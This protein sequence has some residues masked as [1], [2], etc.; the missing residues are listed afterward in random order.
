MW[1]PATVGVVAVASV[2]AG[3]VCE[4]RWFEGLG[5]PGPNDGV[6]AMS[7]FDFDGSGQL[8]PELVVGG[9]FTMAGEALCGSAARWDGTRWLAL[10]TSTSPLVFGFASFDADGAGSGSTQLYAGATFNLR[11]SMYVWDGETWQDVAPTI[12]LSARV[13]ESFDPDGEGPLPGRLIV[14]GAGNGAAFGAISQW[15]GVQWLP[16]GGGLFGW[17]ST[18]YPQV[19]AMTSFDPDGAGPEPRRLIV[20]GRFQRAGNLTVNSIAAWDGAAWHALGGGFANGAG[21]GSSARG[22]ALVVHDL[23]GSGPQAPSLVAGGWFERAGGAVVRSLA[24]WDGGS[25]SDVSGG[26]SIE[27]PARAGQ[28]LGLA[29]HDSDGSGPHPA[30]LAVSGRFD[31][32]GSVPS[33]NVA[34]LGEGVWTP[35]S[36][37]GVVVYAYNVEHFPLASF[38]PKGSETPVLVGAASFGFE[39][40]SLNL[41]MAAWNGVWTPLSKGIAGRITEFA[42]L[43]T[44]GSGPQPNEVIVA[45]PFSLVDDGIATGLARFDGQRWRSLGQ[46]GPA[47][48][49]AVTT[50]DP[51]GAGPSAGEVWVSGTVPVPG[52]PIHGIAAWNGSSW[53]QIGSTLDFARCFGTFDF[54]G[55]GPEGARTLSCA[56]YYPMTIRAWD[57]SGWIQVGGQFVLSDTNRFE[58]PEMRAMLSHDFDG[59]GPLAPVLVAAGRFDYVYED[60]NPTQIHSVAQWDGLAWRPIGAGLPDFQVKGAVS[61]DADGAGPGVPWLVV[62][63]P[64]ALVWRGTS[65]EN[66]ALPTEGRDIQIFDPDG[67]GGLPES[68]FVVAADGVYRWSGSSWDSLGEMSLHYYGNTT[69]RAEA[70]HVWR[71]SPA[72]AGQLMVGGL[73]EF[74]GGGAPSATFGRFTCGSCYANC[75]GS[76]GAAV[77]TANDFV[78]FLARFVSGDAYANCDGSSAAPVLTAGDFQCF[79]NAYTAGCP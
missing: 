43:D 4:P 20:T 60:G 14:G 16:M 61:F 12:Q 31:L 2:A 40:Q 63:G 65:W 28:V 35:L 52:G 74:A 26:V 30:R 69:S 42:T 72:D 57:G 18:L 38:K 27:S 68:L 78:C 77:L 6:Y 53:R 8:E 44:D 56:G 48:I 1:L 22:N 10:G 3:Q 47:N 58:D 46:V 32:A 13:V 33:L 41:N 75:D 17:N 39:N 45:G 9:R 51:D 29:S 49:L 19:Q 76:T 62:V 67:H 24:R 54:D 15:D 36:D 37:G 70:L 55:S 21:V 66:L 25:W 11:H 64:G 5:R 71:Q 73:F 79:M 50:V 34:A 23:D 59:E 7:T